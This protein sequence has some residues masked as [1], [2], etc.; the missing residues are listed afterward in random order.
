MGETRAKM[1]RGSAECEEQQGQDGGAKMAGPA[2]SR[3]KGESRSI[4]MERFLAWG[5]CF[6]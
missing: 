2:E 5:Q 3:L 1:A 6:T 4:R